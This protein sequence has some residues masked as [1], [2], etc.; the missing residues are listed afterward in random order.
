MGPNIYGFQQPSYLQPQYNPFLPA[1]AQTGFKP[2][3]NYNAPAYNPGQA[4]NY[5]PTPAHQKDLALYHS[6]K[7]TEG[8]LTPSQKTQLQQLESY[9]SNH[10]YGND[11][12]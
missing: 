5:T 9:I 10:Q 4:Q 2:M 7:A 1:Y 11:K 8:T 12:V 6:L 3:F